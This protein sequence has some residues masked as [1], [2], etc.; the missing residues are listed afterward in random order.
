M[1]KKHIFILFSLLTLFSTITVKANGEASAKRSDA[2]IM[3][4]VLDKNSGEHIAFVNIILRGTT[5]GT[6]TDVSGH[7]FLKNLPE[8]KFTMEV[9]TVGYKTITKDVS[10]KKGT[11]LEINFE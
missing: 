9:S 5:I 7:Y 11:T 4:H 6:T 10:L 3:G 1:T 8:G 2:N